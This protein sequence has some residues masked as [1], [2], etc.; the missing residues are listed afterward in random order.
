VKAI[1]P[2]LLE[3]SQGEDRGNPT[4]TQIRRTFSREI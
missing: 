4:K 1:S 2:F 3:E